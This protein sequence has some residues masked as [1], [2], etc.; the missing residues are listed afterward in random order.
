MIVIETFVSR[1]ERR[2]ADERVHGVLTARIIRSPGRQ[3]ATQVLCDRF[4]DEGGEGHASPRGTQGEV[5]IGL[6]G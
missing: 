6:D 4:P 2:A 5:P 1:T 3:G